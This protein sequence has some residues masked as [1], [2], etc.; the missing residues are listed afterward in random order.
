MKI[1]TDP[2][3]LRIFISIVL[4]LGLMFSLFALGNETTFEGIG[5]SPFFG[6]ALACIALF[7]LL[8]FFY[9][10]KTDPKKLDFIRCG[11]VALCLAAMICSFAIPDTS[12]LYVLSPILYLLI[13]IVK[14]ILIIIQRRNT[15]SVIY[16]ALVIIVCVLAILA[17]LSLTGFIE[18]GVYGA[19]TVFACLVIDVT[20]LVNICSMVFSRFNK[21]ILL[22]IVHKT[23]AGE[24]LLGLFLLVVAF[25]LVLMHNEKSVH[26]FGDALWYCFMVITTIG[27][28]DI[29]AVS[30]I[31]RILTVIL[32]VYGIIVVSILTSIIVNFYSE[33]KDIQEDELPAENDAEMKTP[34]LPEKKNKDK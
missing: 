1:K 16:N 23:Y 28:G 33:T 18:Q 7:E 11:Y 12:K 2:K 19:T 13:Y 30:L 4:C 27:F 6:L 24:I 9:H 29:A 17:T 25:S 10:Q 5:A 14:R 22:R 34:D 21:E 3:S 20:C 8:S 31:G 26:T 32:G 15:R